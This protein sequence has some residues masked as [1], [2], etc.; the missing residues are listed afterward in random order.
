MKITSNIR[1]VIVITLINS[2]I[3]FAENLKPTG[4][5][6]SPK[7]PPQSTPE[8]PENVRIVKYG[9]EWARAMD[10]G[11][12]SYCYSRYK[13]FKDP[14]TGKFT[15]SFRGAD[16]QRFHDFDVDG[17]GKADDDTVLFHPFD[18][19]ENNP[20]NVNAPFFDDTV[21]SQR[22]YGGATVYRA[23]DLDP[24]WT[25]EGINSQETGGGMQPARNWAL[26]FDM[27]KRFSPF[28]Y[29]FVALWQKFDFGN[30]GDKY[31]VSLNEQSEFRHYTNRHYVNI[32][33]L[34]WVIRNGN[35]FYISEYVFSGIGLRVHNPAKSRWAKYNPTAP[36]KIDF[37]PEKAKFEEVKF[38]NIT[39]IGY[40][41]FK[42]RLANGHLSYK[43]YAF[44]GEAVVHKPDAPSQNIDMAELKSGSDS[45]YMTTCEIPYL[46]WRRVHRLAR[47]NG[48]AGPRGFNFDSYGDMGSMAFPDA[49][50]NYL[51]HGQNE[52]VTHLS[53]ADAIAWC[54]ALSQQESKLPCYYTDPEFK[55]PF[56][57]V[58]Y[59]PF[60]RPEMRK[61]TIYV[62]W[63]ANGYRLPTQDEWLIGWKNGNFAAKQIPRSNSTSPVGKIKGDNVNLYDLSGN[64]WEMV[65]THGDSLNLD[66]YKQYTVM[67]GDFRDPAKP[68][69]TSAS[70]YGDKPFLGHPCVGFRMVR[71]QSGLS[72]PI[73]TSVK[74][75]APTWTITRDTLTTPHPERQFKLP[76]RNYLDMVPVGELKANVGKYE[77]TYA[78]WK[79]VYDWAVS[80]GYE[81]DCTGEMGS[82][83]YWGWGPD[84]KPIDHGPT[85]PVTGITQYDAAV[86]L[87]ALSELEGLKP[88]IYTDEKHTEPFK[89]SHVYRPPQVFF[90]EGQ[91]KREVT[92]DVNPVFILSDCK[93]EING[94][95]EYKEVVFDKNP[96]Y[97]DF[98]YFYEDP[99]ANGYRMPSTAEYKKLIK[100]GTNRDLPDNVDAWLLNDSGLTT[101]PV[102]QKTAD[103]FGLHDIIGNVNEM[104]DIVD[105]HPEKTRNNYA[106]VQRVGGGFFDVN[107][108]LF[109]AMFESGFCRSN[110]RGLP[111]PDTGFRAL[112]QKTK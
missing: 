22:V 41:I 45:F 106:F 20:F 36:Y 79:P 100:P 109:Y 105:K 49:K 73:K 97:G 110:S 42:D 47:Y 92:E 21:G 93:N 62:N 66:E 85:E 18:L 71:R 95:V 6:W 104:G 55:V 57:E 33:G 107:Y 37:D 77:I 38:D 91:R 86:W 11:V 17:D 101:H 29:Y 50:G 53:F 28:R 9:V 96:F 32:D 108:G 4:E 81:F 74:T 24:N 111:Y 16:T 34:R 78:K 83:S 27:Y 10:G 67:G 64:V 31:R 58:I 80:K 69:A 90:G 82:M 43:W 26:H 76:V 60:W 25:E 72:A 3:S 19:S 46:L 48:F 61:T 12:D 87:N 5:I 13:T 94:A 23:N 70:A 63:A 99:S 84:W 59:P 40:Y 14:K 8:K 44:E 56:R 52:P 112:Q 68:D 7:P 39:A 88:V 98:P 54:N 89:R 75:D 30:D 103:S 1:F 15:I 35:D 51:S 102:G 2:S 65:W